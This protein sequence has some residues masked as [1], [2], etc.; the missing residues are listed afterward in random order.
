MLKYFKFIKGGSV[1]FR[2]FLRDCSVFHSYIHLKWSELRALL[3]TDANDSEMKIKLR[4]IS[5]LRLA[6]G[7]VEDPH[8]FDAVADPHPAFHLNADHDPK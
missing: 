7:S 6:I 1:C 8:H 4:T 2:G 3:Q 5:T